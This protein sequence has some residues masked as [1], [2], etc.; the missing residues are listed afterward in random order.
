MSTLM[1]F[2]VGSEVLQFEAGGDYPAKRKQ[3]LLQAKDRSAAGDL[4]IENLGI[5]IKTRVIVF[6]L[7]SKADY[8]ALV[9]WFLNVAQGG[10]L[11]FIFTDEYGDAGEVRIMDSIIDFD[12][13]SLEAYS[14]SITLEYTP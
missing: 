7:M 10:S 11:P 6:N 9:D 2:E 13:N 4:Q 3:E 14:G 1:K 12:E 5:K 8:V